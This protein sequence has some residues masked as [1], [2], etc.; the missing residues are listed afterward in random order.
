MADRQI[1]QLT[2]ASTPE[3]TDVMPIQKVDGSAE[4]KSTSISTLS[5]VVLGE[6]LTRI[7]Y[8][9]L[10]L[11][12]S[13]TGLIPGRKYLM[14]DYQTI[15]IIPNT[16]AIN[17][18][19]T[20]PIIITATSSS[21]IDC[22]VQ[23]L[24]YPKDIIY[25]SITNNNSIVNGSTKGYIYRRIDT[26][27][28]NDIPFDFRAVKFRR[29]QI[30]VTTQD[31]T[32]AVGNYTV[33]QVVKKTSTTQIY[34]KLNNKTAVPF[35]DT[36]S[37]TVLQF[38][39][40]DKVSPTNTNWLIV[41]GTFTVTL[42]CTSTYTD[43]LLFNN[44]TYYADAYNNSIEKPNENIID[45]TNTVFYFNGIHDN[46]I[47][48]NFTNNSIRVNFQYNNI[49]TNFSNNVIGED[50]TY[51]KIGDY[52][53]N[54]VF[55]GTNSYNKIDYNYYNNV[56]GAIGLGNVIGIGYN[57]NSMGSVFNANTIGQYCSENIYGS[58]VYKNTFDNSFVL[59]TLGNDCIANRIGA[60]F[61]NNIIVDN[62]RQNDFCTYVQSFDFS[63]ATHVY[64]SYSCSIYINS[65][66]TLYLIYLLGSAQQ[67]V[68]ATS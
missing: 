66:G 43:Y 18:G 64:G 1:Y 31:A 35:T 24:S 19:A 59:N 58:N 49:G 7:S 12:I 27:Q 55:N 36:G 22:I 26:I 10:V 33:G 13:N 30:D 54:N 67:V 60:F 45:N 65:V 25:Y 57:S 50:F 63:S 23:S 28:N 15:H 32:G 9:D 46:K 17:V 41:N 68:G 47:G 14:L 3:L 38:D 21:T 51:N 4:A 8:A 56:M 5:T 40:L 39:N 29:W 2:D 20:E 42:P 62:F 61:F 52:C 16:S 6:L 44:S 34:I 37:W 48:S 11:L 53:Y